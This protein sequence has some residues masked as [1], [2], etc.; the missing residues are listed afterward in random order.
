MK[1]ILCPNCQK[2]E[3]EI[4][5]VNSVKVKQCKICG[6]IYQ[7]GEKELGPYFLP[8]CKDINGNFIRCPRCGSTLFTK[9]KD[10]N[11]CAEFIWT[12]YFFSPRHQY[13]YVPPS[14]Y[15]YICLNRSCYFLWNSS[16]DL[17]SPY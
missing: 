1:D 15:E 4:I 17:E 12:H 8:N 13:R 6:F 16:L 2:D 5:E 11:T 14:E 9:T 7:L 10:L 3:Y